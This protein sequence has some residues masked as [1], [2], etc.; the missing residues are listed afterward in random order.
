MAFVPLFCR[1][2]YSPLGISSCADIVRRARS[3]SYATL[4]LC[5]EATM[6]G[7]HEFDEECSA[8]GIRPVFG[9]RVPLPGL[10]LTD[11]AFPIDFLI[12]SEQG[13]RNLVRILTHFHEQR[14]A[15]D[16]GPR[17]KVALKGRVAGLRPTLPPGGELEALL[18]EKDRGRTE[19]FLALAAD[20]LG[21]GLVI[22]VDRDGDA[23]VGSLLRK[24]AAFLKVPAVAA[25]VIAYC[26]PSDAAAHAYLTHPEGPPDRTWKQPEPAESL[27]ALF[28]EEAMLTRFPEGDEA[29]HESGELARRC[30]WRPR[31]N[32]RIIPTQDFERGFDANSY[33]F[34][35]VI[36]GANEQYGAINEEVKQR[37]NRE[38]EEIKSQ[39]LATYLLLY[40]DMISF[41]DKEG[42]SRGVGRGSVVASVLAYCL[43]ITRIDPLQYRLAPHPLVAE[44]ETFPTLRL[45]VSSGAAVR[46]LE[47]L[48]STFGEDHV[49]QIGRRQE[50]RRE[51]ILEELAAWAGMTDDE[52]RLALRER[53]R[54][55]PG[56]AAAH[57]KEK[58]EE[59]RWRR[60]RDP[61]FLAEVA[62]RLAPRPRPLAPAGA[63]WTLS[64]E[65]LEYVIPVIKV[66]GETR[67]TDISE[68]AIDGLGAPRIEFVPHHLLNLL[69]RARQAALQATPGISAFRIPEN[70]RA[71]FDIIARGET[72]GIVP[73]AGITTKCMLRK[74]RPGNLLQLL[75]VKTEAAKAR[76]AE[77][78]ISLIE[79]LPD[80]LI[81]YQCAYFRAN[82]PA[83]YFAAALS[84]AAEEGAEVSCLLAAVRR[85][86]IGVD[87]PD[88]NLSSALCTLQGGRIRLGLRMIR[89]FGEKAWD[90]IQGVRRGGRFNS[91]EDFC[92][93]V[94]SRTI[95]HRLLQNLIGAGAF[96]G[97]N[98]SRAQMSAMAGN[99]QRKA[100]AANSQSGGDLEGQI[101]LFEL[102]EELSAPITE[103]EDPT[104]E[105]AEWD[106]QTLHRRER[107]ALGFSLS[108]GLA[109]RFPK[110]LSNLKPVSAAQIQPR[111]AGRQVRLAGVIDQIDDEGPL[112]EQEGARLVDIEGVPVWLNPALAAVSRRSL[113]VGTEAL[114]IGEVSTRHGYTRIEAQGLWRISD[115]E[116]QAERVV[117]IRL[118]LADENGTTLRH[119]IHLARLYRGEG[120]IETTGYP[121]PRSLLHRF[122]LR[123]RVFFCSPFY[124]GLC[125]ILP[126]ERVELFD[127]AGRLLTIAV[128]SDE[129][130]ENSGN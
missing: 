103:S 96:D 55:G 97:F 120:R 104:G 25:P 52:K 22:G 13:Y 98:Q 122:L 7:F 40:R 121:S 100:R 43:S 128:S 45:E 102:E 54:R 29:A 6:A 76:S 16:S 69:D 82:H 33:L 115:L 125:K 4:G 14:G 114:A 116:D 75:R 24:L 17:R 59:K 30:L 117:R 28:T 88:I 79:E 46:L 34:D 86:G 62:A 42:L 106:R 111:L 67:L 89:H 36:R 72:I 110:T 20:V 83:A 11:R 129:E 118:N 35:L 113:E 19:Q 9:V 56:A 124:Q 3:L 99:L 1:S 8:Q 64:A 78:P 77:R 92:Q 10:L 107:E 18:R 65:P 27:P 101:M 63:R 84:T 5:D 130:S 50:I 81:S 31:L 70:D 85:V 57:L 44:N 53:S 74:E 47:H 105:V 58:A 60:W 23:E 51:Q 66:Q 61:A 93:G 12:E 48:R 80:V 95:N 71:T 91:F 68:A 90:E 39:N 109:E 108:S 41:L 126:V 15:P 2:H 94:S 26:E 32:R 87:P 73:L 123:H 119:L 21:P 112:M 37:I 127:A 38:F 49:A